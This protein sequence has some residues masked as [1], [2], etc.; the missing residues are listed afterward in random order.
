MERTVATIVLLL[1]Q[2]L[3]VNSYNAPRSLKESVS[4]AG[5]KH[6]FVPAI[7]VSYTCNKANAASQRGV[8]VDTNGLFDVCPSESPLP[9]CVSSQDDR[10]AYFA[11]PWEYDGSSYEVAKGKIMSYISRKYSSDLYTLQE[12]NERYLRYAFSVGKQTNQQDILEFYFT[13]NDAL[14]QF[15][16]ERKT[17]DD[18]KKKENILTDF[19]VNAKRLESIR[20]GLGFEMVPILRNRRRTFIFGESPFDSFGPSTVQFEKIIDNVSGDEAF[21]KGLGLPKRDVMKDVDPKA[22]AYET[23]EFQIY[24]SIR[25]R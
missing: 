11:N 12:D 15:K 10:P 7:A 25:R 24:E 3:V 2:L 4:K 19:Q 18:K 1:I 5:W 9:V 13:P 17:I 22:R 23:P 14:V 20:I 6:L 8:G 21:D 16:S